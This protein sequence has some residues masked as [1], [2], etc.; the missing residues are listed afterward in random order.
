MYSPKKQPFSSNGNR[1]WQHGVGLTRGS[2]SDGFLEFGVVLATKLCATKSV[3]ITVGMFNLT[4]HTGELKATW[5]IY[6]YV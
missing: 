1:S 2:T 4:V 6:I 3:V 5:Y